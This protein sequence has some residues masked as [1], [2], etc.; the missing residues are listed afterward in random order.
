[1]FQL[2]SGPIKPSANEIDR[3]SAVSGDGGITEGWIG[4]SVICSD[5]C[6]SV[7]LLSSFEEHP[8]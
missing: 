3:S 2:I 6:S 5:S 7:K 4:P 1:M 8:K